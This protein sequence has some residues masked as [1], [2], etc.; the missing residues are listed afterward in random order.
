LEAVSPQT[1]SLQSTLT[2]VFAP[3]HKRALGIAVGVAGG[4][5]IA[6]ATLLHLVVPSEH[7]PPVALLGQFFYG[8]NVSWPGLVIGFAWGFA[9]G[10]VVGWS[11]AFLRN[12]FTAL[13]L[14]SI[15]AKSTL[16]RPFLDEI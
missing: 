14:L 11:L 12:V 13:W 16:S 7:E 2:Y 3:M 15:R 4:G 1:H 8:Y 10:F 9:T 6:L 5:L